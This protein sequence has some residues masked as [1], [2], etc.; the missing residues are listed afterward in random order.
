VNVPLPVHPLPVPAKTHDP[1]IEPP[2]TVPVKFNAALFPF[3]EVAVNKNLPET[4]PLKFPLSTNDPVSVPCVIEQLGSLVVK[5][6][7]LTVSAPLLVFS[8][9]DVVKSNTGLLLESVSAAVQFPFTFPP[10]PLLPE[11]H[12]ASIIPAT[13]IIAA[14]NFIIMNKL[15]L[16]FRGPL[17]RER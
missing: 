11:P 6:K 9:K 1:L 3:P 16:E 7:L 13:T 5:L 15:L 10:L 4:L 8:D 12:P 14:T 17:A 2:F